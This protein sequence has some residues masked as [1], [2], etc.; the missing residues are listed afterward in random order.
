MIVVF[1][2]GRRQK[3][4]LRRTR[5]PHIAN[6]NFA[7]FDAPHQVEQKDQDRQR[8]QKAGD[9]DDQVHVVETLRGIIIRDA[10]AH[11]QQADVHLTKRNCPERRRH[12]K[13]MQFAQR[14]V[15]TPPGHFGKPVIDCREEGKHKSAEH[16]VVEMTDDPVRVVQVQISGDGSVGRTGQAAEQEHDDRADDKP[17]CGIKFDFPFP[18]RTD[19]RKEFDAGRHGDEQR[20]VHKRHA[21]IFFHPGR[22]HVMRPHKETDH[23]NRERRK[24]DPF[25]TEQ[26]LAR[27]DWQ[28]F[29]DDAETGQNKNVHRRM[30]V[31]PEQ[32]LE[33]NRVATFCRVEKAHSK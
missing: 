16:C 1:R 10:A 26:R 30:R 3:R 27:K 31:E 15:H 9:G 5:F 12:Q 20:R 19:P 4:P 17:H 2:R 22:E 29:A 7:V 21:Q 13:E 33:Q 14:L 25:V 24:R 32:M 28:Q 23:R 8:D 6:G 18:Q 11:S